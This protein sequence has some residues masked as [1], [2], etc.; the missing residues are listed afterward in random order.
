MP[1]PPGPLAEAETLPCPCPL[2]LSHAPKVPAWP[3]CASRYPALGREALPLW[4]T[5][6][7]IG[8]FCDPF[9]EQTGLAGGTCSDALQVLLLACQP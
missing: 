9:A 4:R 1:L 5:G 3:P 2:A 6:G 7:F 8:E